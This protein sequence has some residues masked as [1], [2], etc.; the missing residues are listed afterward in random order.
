MK[1]NY[2]HQITGSHKRWVVGGDGGGS[3]VRI[4][5]V[6]GLLIE[7]NA[8]R[9]PVSQYLPLVCLIYIIKDHCIYK[10]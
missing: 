1:P 10:N 4:G 6:V 9:N 8:T 7:L 2:T 3:G 5:S